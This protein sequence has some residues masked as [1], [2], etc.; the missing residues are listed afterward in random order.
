MHDED[1]CC[2]CL[3]SL[4]GRANVASRLGSR[5]GSRVASR[6]SRRSSLVG[7]FNFIRAGS[8][9]RPSRPGTEAGADLDAGEAGHVV[10]LPGC[11]H[12]FHPS[13]IRL[14]LERSKICPMCKR[15][16]LQVKS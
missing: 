11:G 13:C 10:R 4:S 9:H 16:A 14:W 2:I 3:C 1:V 15:P 5:L 7:E 8:S 12:V 6:R